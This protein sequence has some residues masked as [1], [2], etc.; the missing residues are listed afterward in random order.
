MIRY[1]LQYLKPYTYRLIL[2]FLLIVSA[3]I[4]ALAT[5]YFLKIIID[6]VFPKGNYQDLLKIVCILLFI[7]IFRI[8]VSFWCSILHTSISRSIVADMRVD[9]F[10]GVL[11]KDNA[12]FRE[13][14]IGEIIFLITND[15]ENIQDA[16]TSLA[17]SV[18][19]N[20]IT[21]LGILIMLLILDAQLAI[22]GLAVIPIMIFITKVYTKKIG[23]SFEKIQQ[24]DSLIY[25]FFLE[26]LQ[27]IRI[28]KIYKTLNIELSNAKQLH[29]KLVDH[30]IKNASYRAYSNNFTT[31]FMAIGPLLVITYGGK[32]VFAGVLTLGA[33][34]AF[35][36]YLNKL[37]APTLGLINNYNDFI[38]AR[39]SMGRVYN[40]LANFTSSQ[41]KPKLIE[42]VNSPVN[43]DNITLNDITIAYGNQ[44]VLTNAQAT[45][46]K[47]KI[48]ALVGDSGS[49]KSSI[50]NLLC[51]FIKPTAGNILINGA[52]IETKSELIKNIALIEKENQIFSGTILYNITYGETT[53]SLKIENAIKLS[54]L[55]EVLKTL[56]NGIKTE[57]NSSNTTLSDGQKQRISIA[58][59]LLKNPS[60][61]IIDEATSSL[62]SKKETL[63]LKNIQD[64]FK[65]TIVIFITHRLKSLEHCDVIFEIRDKQ[66]HQIGVPIY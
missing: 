13:N 19:N 3:S 60:I 41:P 27:N 64:H 26:R 52:H 38:K 20:I 28:L 49:G 7:Y 34:I 6:N 16:I 1:Y 21:V 63:I 10:K 43:I 31:F 15:V 57:I 40:N 9:I 30:H 4:S 5:P 23:E 54:A 18:I 8:A 66:L 56:P 44:I 14:K 35:I 36:Q 46:S 17:L 25:N 53:S 55:D 12:Y 45:F 47:G 32:Q 51:G 65:N 58:R 50:I 33:L 48:H 39:I 59:A 37:Y 61:L 24:S 29:K 42:T 11:K 2:L 62:D 22:V